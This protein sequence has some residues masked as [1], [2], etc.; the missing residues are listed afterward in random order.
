MKIHTVTKIQM[1]Y[2]CKQVQEDTNVVKQQCQGIQKRTEDKSE[3]SPILALT[4]TR[5]KEKQTGNTIAS[6]QR[7]NVSSKLLRA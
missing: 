6:W 7:K 3:E 4:R 1:I 2:D 5:K